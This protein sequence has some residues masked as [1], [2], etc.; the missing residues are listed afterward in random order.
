MKNITNHIII[1]IARKTAVIFGVVISAGMSSQVRIGGTNSVSNTSSS[2]V[3][4]EFGTDDN[5]GIILPYVET[6]PSG[7]N[8][9]RG[10]TIIFDVSANSEYKVKVKNE[11]AGWSDL[12]RISGYSASVESVVK[13]PQASPL[14]DKADAKAVIGNS[15]TSTDGVLVLDSPDKAM[16]LPIVSNYTNIPNPSPGMM[17]FLKHPT[18][19][20]KH[21]L[22]VFNGQKWTF[23]KP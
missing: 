12:S 10:G 2:S 22:I 19:S 4:L 3:L 21:R 9:A 15:A 1:N 8:N 20:S 18:D 5:K 13:P 7:A 23:W 14:S 16:V 11:N 17:A 6:I